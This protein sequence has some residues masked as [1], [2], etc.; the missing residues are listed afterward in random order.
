MSGEG[1]DIYYSESDQERGQHKNHCNRA[2]TAWAAMA[3][4]TSRLFD[5]VAFLA[6]SGARTYN[7]R[8]EVPPPERA[9]TSKTAQ[10]NE[11]GTQLDQ[12]DA[13]KERLGEDFNPSLVVISLGG[14]D[15][16]F[17]TIGIMCLAP[18]DCIEKRELW[19][20]NLD[21]VGRRPERDVRR[22]PCSS[23]R[24]PPCW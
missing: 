9:R 19:E 23:S 10:Y 17:S 16:G 13:L 1:A 6:C 3:G 4:Q 15:A 14:N 18:G 21:E 7:V 12:V 24:M 5:S 8:H 20:R 22:D 11:P 2:P